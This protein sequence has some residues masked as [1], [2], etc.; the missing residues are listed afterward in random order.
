MVITNLWL[1]DFRCFHEV[2]FEPDP[3]GLTV[4]RGKN[5]AG[6]TSILEAVGWLATQRSLRGSPREAL[7]RSGASQAVV[8]AQTTVGGRGVLV[9]SEVPLVGTTRSQV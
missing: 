9:E 3:Q 2:T 6:K 4:L 5:G 1:T 8:R 7:V